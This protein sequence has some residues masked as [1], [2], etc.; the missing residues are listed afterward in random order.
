MS[1]LTQSIRFHDMFSLIVF[2]GEMVSMTSIS[3]ATAMTKVATVSN[4]IF[5]TILSRPSRA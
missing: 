2:D 1:G 3:A 4:V 5:I